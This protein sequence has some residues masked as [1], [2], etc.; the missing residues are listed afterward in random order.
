MVT[1]LGPDASQ[2]DYRLSPTCGHDDATATDAALTYRLALDSGARPIERIGSGWRE[3]GH[4]PEG[5]VLV[6]EDDIDQVRAIMAG[7]DPTTGAWLVRPKQVVATSAKL[8][9]GPLVAAIHATAEQA[10]HPAHALLPREQAKRLE[11]LD[12]G[13]V[14]DGEA[15][16][17]PVADLET[18][19]A[20]AGVDITTVYE[21]PELA[22]A[23]DHRD[24][25]VRVGNRGYDVTIDVPK[26]VSVL[27]G[28]ADE[29]TAGRVEELYMQAV[30]ESV[31]AL[32][33][34][35]A[36][37]M[38]GHHGDG[39]TAQAVATSGFTGTIT[40]H[41]TARPVQ[42]QA[43]DPH[44]HAHVML[45]NMVRCSD[46]EWRTVAAG[47]RDLHRHVAA[48]GE[49][50]RARVRDL[51]SREYGVVWTQDADTGRWDIAG[52]DTDVRDLYSARR[53]QAIA[54]AGS[55]A[56]A[57]QQRRA[58][59][60][61]AGEKQDLTPGEERQAWRERAE[62]AGHDSAEIVAAALG[63]EPPEAGPDHGQDPGPDRP[64]PRPDPEDVA[65]AVWDPEHG[66]T[67][68]N[69]VVSRARVMAAVAG[70]CPDGLAS[71][72]ELEELTDAVVAEAPAVRMPEAGQAHMSNADRY[73]THD[74]LE[75]EQAVIDSAARRRDTGA[76]AVEERTAA[77]AI[78]A[79]EQ[80]KGYTLSA[81][82]RAVVDRL[83]TAGHGLDAVI[84][85]AGSGKTTI[86]AAARGGWEATGVRVAGASTAAVAA[87]QLR[88]EAGIHSRT[89]AAWQRRIAS[90]QGLAGTDVLVLDEA[91][92]VDDRAMAQLSEAAERSGTK[93][94]GIGDPQQLRAVGIGG[95]F[96]RVHEVTGGLTLSEN[97][98]QRGDTDRAALA[99]WRQG[100]HQSALTTWGQSGRVHIGADTETAYEAMATAWWADRRGIADPHAAVSNVLLL[101]PTHADVDAL[102]HRC[103][104]IAR[105]QGMLSGTDVRWR[106]RG[107]G[108]IALAT[109]DQVR[110]T[111]N[112]YRSRRTDDEPDVLNGYRGVV[113]QA[114]ERRGALVEWRR[115]EGPDQVTE[116]A[117]LGPDAIARGDLVHAYAATIASTQGQTAE[118]AHVYG[119]GAQAH[120]LYPAMSRARGATHLYLPGVDT[121]E[122]PEQWATAGAPSTAED[123]QAR[124]IAAYAA[125]LGD[126]NDG[127]ALDEITGTPYGLE[128]QQPQH[129]PAEATHAEEHPEH[130]QQQGQTE[131]APIQPQAET[132][133]E[134]EATGEQRDRASQA[135]P[136]EETE[137][138][139]PLTRQAAYA[140]QGPAATA[141]RTQIQARQEALQAAQGRL[142]ELRSAYTAAR[143][144]AEQGRLR[145][146]M[147]GSSRRAADEQAQRTRDELDEALAETT[148][149]RHDDG[150]LWRSAIQT[151]LRQAIADEHEAELRAQERVLGLSREE[152][153]AR[154]MAERRAE[155]A[156]IRARDTALQGSATGP[157]QHRQPPERDQHEHDSARAHHQAEREAHRQCP[158]PE[159][160]L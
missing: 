90:G 39:Q 141:A 137:P 43:G 114:G 1:V 156:G 95:T 54:A 80:R 14:R 72:D 89:I 13:L 28:L 126:P 129:E 148:Q 117:W 123:E 122:S 144:H 154:P 120:G 139:Q 49:L 48:V 125:T 8:P 150:G 132:R 111:R 51:L 47:G 76:A 109:G 70:A 97:R 55:E 73:T 15:H 110:I 63:R 91:A 128:G 66:V 115:T 33:G 99:T 78:A 152:L 21:A 143:D 23:Q 133:P 108:A 104:A 113:V 26:S 85:V 12:R 83:L 92:M 17:A 71:T 130:D 86:M 127:I 60:Q 40:L 19:A 31:S 140:G 29:Q 41:R 93:I 75:A 67:S 7:R 18:L 36:Y 88:S 35:T 11:R 87:D 22:E 118:R 56:S 45:A 103:R 79:F 52:I 142:P 64:P 101:A 44:L 20:A 61:H 84:G 94:V 157:V 134:P 107:G 124:A 5:S 65:A 158:G 6:D 112:D 58:A 77:E 82:Q 32:E 121:L 16:R 146:W 81:E 3:H 37:G 42:G 151:D 25:R 116:R 131:Q 155:V 9:G 159:I 135:A 145:L 10:G 98:R 53:D 74:V 30:R 147:A 34:W 50:A 153:Q 59:R 136:E 105:D 57:A 100:G 102:N 96:A 106:T 138:W 149:L 46:G 27:W 68:G 24:E 2:V 38:A 69:K 160:E 62:T 119:V 4:T